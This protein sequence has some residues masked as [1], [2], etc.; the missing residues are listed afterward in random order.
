M[1]IDSSLDV[2]GDAVICLGEVDDE[3]PELRVAAGLRLEPAHDGLRHRFQQQRP[4]LRHR[5]YHLLLLLQRR[6]PPG[7]SFFLCLVLLLPCSCGR[8]TAAVEGFTD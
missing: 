7:S 6:Q 1:T 3:L 8:G 4:E 2:C 5:K